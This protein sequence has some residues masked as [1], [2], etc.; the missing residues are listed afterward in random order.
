MKDVICKE[1]RKIEKN[2]NV[3]ILLAVESGSRAWGFVSPDSDYDVRFIY[4][5]REED[6]LRL[7][8]YRDV[9]ELPIDDKLDIN[10]WDLQKALKLLYKSNPTLFE[11]FSSPIVYMETDFANEFRSVMNQYFSF[12]K[13]L[14][15]YINMAKSNYREYL[16]GETVRVKKYFYVLR[17][18]LACRWILDK[19]TPPPMLFSEL[20]KSELS[21][22]LI[23]DVE[24]LLD[25]KIN[26]PEIKEIPRVDSV[27]AYIEAS[28]GGIGECIKLMGE[29]KEVGMEELN[30]LFLK[31]VRQYSYD[32]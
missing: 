20:M 8:K 11:W 15:H 19:G 7:E 12:K 28:I 1:L 31:T 22:E 9:I 23:P 2:Q 6:Y 4:V 10:G 17:P 24:R 18:I 13:A 26:S 27:N 21:V 16:R 25:L 29:K 32:S 5:Q 14:Y 30:K 3:K